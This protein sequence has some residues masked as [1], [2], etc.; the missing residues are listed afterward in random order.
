MKELLFTIYVIAACLGLAYGGLHV[1]FWR[2]GITVPKG[3]DMIGTVAMPVAIFVLFGLLSM[4]LGVLI[5]K[6]P[7]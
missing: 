7:A 2:Y 3:F 5:L 1:Y 4:M 6:T